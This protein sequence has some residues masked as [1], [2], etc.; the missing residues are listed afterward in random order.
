MPE[1]LPELLQDAL[2][3]LTYGFT[4]NQQGMSGHY[5]DIAAKLRYIRY[6]IK[7]HEKWALECSREW[8]RGTNSE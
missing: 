1:N 3:E 6:K 4:D 8:E 7:E 5:R 2:Y